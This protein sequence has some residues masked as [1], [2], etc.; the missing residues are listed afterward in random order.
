M[1]DRFGNRDL[2]EFRKADFRNLATE[3]ER[4]KHGLMFGGKEHGARATDTRTRHDRTR[5]PNAFLG[6]SF[7]DKTII[8]L[9]MLLDETVSVG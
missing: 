5:S 6:L 9:A 3:N 7:N 8:F 1:R 4:A 2:H